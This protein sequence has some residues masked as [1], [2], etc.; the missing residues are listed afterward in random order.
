[1]FIQVETLSAGT[2]SVVLSVGPPPILDLITFS[3]FQV[4]LG[5]FSVDTNS[6]LESRCIALFMPELNL[7]RAP[8]MIVP[9]VFE[10]HDR[11]F[12]KAR[13]EVICVFARI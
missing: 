2:L 5:F 7:F 8:S 6:P 4:P 1:L 13:R 10:P 11:T 9:E 3:S 12:E